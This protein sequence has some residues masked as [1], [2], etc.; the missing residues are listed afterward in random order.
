MISWKAR[1]GSA[2]VVLHL[3]TLPIV[4]PASMFGKKNNKQQQLHLGPD[5]WTSFPI[6]K[7]KAIQAPEII[8]ETLILVYVTNEFLKSWKEQTSS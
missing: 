6:Q 2:D 1:L 4:Y 3:Y 5:K 7:A 8:L